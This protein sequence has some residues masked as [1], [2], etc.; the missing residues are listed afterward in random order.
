[1]HPSF[2]ALV[3][4]MLAAYAAPGQ[5]HASPPVSA[6][7]AV[8]SS[9]HA[10]ESG[11]RAEYVGD[12][13][14]QSC[15]Q[16]TVETF[17]RTSHYLTSRLA[18]AASILGEFTPDVNVMKSSNRNLFFRMEKKENGFFQ[19][20]IEGV[21]PFITERSERFAFVIGSGGK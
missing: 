21:A 4:L 14:C 11:I 7:P 15:H 17:H 3:V 9:L 18:E 12:A 16:D 2:H 19:T 5:T 13:A 1:M 8:Q 6:A 20:A 10:Q